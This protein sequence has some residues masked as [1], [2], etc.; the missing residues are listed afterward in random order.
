MT[1]QEGPVNAYCFGECGFA[2]F[3]WDLSVTFGNGSTEK[4]LIC[5]KEDCP[6]EATRVGP[7]EFPSIEGGAN[8]ECPKSMVV[9]IRI[10]LE[11]W[12]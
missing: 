4:F 12:Q 9:F 2:V 1:K 5:T 7:T 6:Y 11:A 8:G 10:L 3:N